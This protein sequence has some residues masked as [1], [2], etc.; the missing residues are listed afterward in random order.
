[1]VVNELEPCEGLKKSCDGPVAV[2][3]L[4][5]RLT[6]VGSAL[7]KLSVA[8]GTKIGAKVESSASDVGHLWE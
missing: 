6:E 2:W 8:P 4:S 1:M 7:L 3:D 5:A